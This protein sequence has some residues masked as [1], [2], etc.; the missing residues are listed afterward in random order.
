MDPPQHSSP[1]RQKR[2][3]PCIHCRK[4]IHIPVALPATKAPCPHCG[5]EV[6]S[7]SIPEH[8]LEQAAQAPTTATKVTQRVTTTQE[9]A[10]ERAPFPRSE[11]IQAKRLSKLR[12]MPL[13]ALTVAAVAFVPAILVALFYPDRLGSSVV[14]IP[15][16]SERTAAAV[17]KAK[18]YRER[19]WQADA[20][21][22]LTNFQNAKTI[23]ERAQFTL[24]GEAV[25]PAME[26]LYQEYPL[27]A[28]DTPV[29]GFTPVSLPEVDTSR[30]I[31]LMNYSRPEQY[32]MRQFFRPLAPLRVEYG[33]EPRDFALESESSVTNFVSEPV[34]VMAYFRQTELG[35]LRLDWS[36][37]SQTKYRL[38]RSFLENAQAGVSSVFRVFVQED[39]GRGDAA[40]I[41]SSVYRISD[42]AFSEDHIKVRIKD[43]SP[44][45][46]ALSTLRKESNDQQ[47]APTRGATVEL[48]W[49]SGPKPQLRLKNFL[50]WEFLNL[51]G[52]LDNWREIPKVAP[53]APPVEK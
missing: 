39:V 38:F 4:A 49:G 14:E 36:L 53:T 42:P 25:I 8:Y 32:D 21:R 29:A 18:A 47:E 24:R 52:E 44:L 11:E 20:I 50:C 9:P 19:G 15:S 23:A 12:R 33:L 37:Y 16:K 31:F 43:E 51:G 41:G 2:S 22:V 30:G 35:K 10:A 28:N 7:P 45:G 26:K 34:R 48:E 46:R 40:L 13:I 6:T 5:V 27:D 17:R 3:F 1:Q